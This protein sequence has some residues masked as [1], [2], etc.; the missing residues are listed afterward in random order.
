MQKLVSSD[1]CFSNKSNYFEQC[2]RFWGKF[3]DIPI[4]RVRKHSVVPK[5]PSAKELKSPMR[6]PSV[7]K[8]RVTPIKIKRQASIN[9]KH[10]DMYFSQISQKKSYRKNVVLVPSISFDYS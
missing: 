1:S 7:F 2:H 6:T 10:H 5:K 9:I 3:E 4:I 8:D